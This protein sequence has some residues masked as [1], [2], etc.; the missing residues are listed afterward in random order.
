[1]RIIKASQLFVLSATGDILKMQLFFSENQ[2]E[3]QKGA[4]SILP[5]K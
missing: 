4:S 5:A 3:R 2:Q 1:V